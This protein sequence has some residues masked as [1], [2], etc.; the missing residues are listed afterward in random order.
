MGGF[1][2]SAIAGTKRD[3]VGCS[4]WIPV[5]CYSWYNAGGCYKKGQSNVIVVSLEQRAEW[6]VMLACGVYQCVVFISVWC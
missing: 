2:W 3:R 4:G 6:P 1:Q 5:E